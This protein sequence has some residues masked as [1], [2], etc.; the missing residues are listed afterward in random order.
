L[1]GWGVRKR[2]GVRTGW[3]VR[4]PVENGVKI[5]K[6]INGKILKNIYKNKIKMHKSTNTMEENT[7]EE[8]DKQPTAKRAQRNYTMSY[9][10]EYSTSGE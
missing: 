3:G 1:E 2:W 5:T 6:K 8:A 7:I 10:N 9:R 4:R